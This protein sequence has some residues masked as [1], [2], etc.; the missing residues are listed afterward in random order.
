MESSNFPGDKYQWLPGVLSKEQL[1]KL[2]D[3]GYLGN[4][5]DFN[6]AS[7]FSSID[8]HISDVGYKMVNGSIK[9]FGSMYSNVLSDTKYA[10]KL[11]ADERGR[12]F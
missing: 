11:V 3:T 1:S 6:K 10:E 2:V 5:V 4:I 12:F 7:D 8:L 9:P